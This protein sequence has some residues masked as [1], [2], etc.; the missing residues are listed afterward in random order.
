MNTQLKKVLLSVWPWTRTRMKAAPMLVMV[1]AL[2][3]PLAACSAQLTRTSGKSTSSASTSALAT[4]AAN[5][6]KTTTPTANASTSSTPVANSSAATSPTSPISPTSTITP[7]PTPSTATSSGSGASATPA[8]TP[9]ST[10]TKGTKPSAAQVAAI[11][12]VIQHANQEQIQAL[13]AGNPASMQDTSTSSYYTELVQTQNTMENSGVASIQLVKLTWGPITLTNATTAR[14]TDVETWN[15]TFSGQAG[16][17]QQSNT[18][19]YVLVL[20]NG[21]WK[22]QSDQQPTT[23]QSPSGNSNPSGNPSPVAPTIP[24]PSAPTSPNALSQS[25]NWAGYAASG[26]DFTSVSGSWGVPKVT[27]AAATSA[28]ATWVGIGGVNSQD[29]IQ[30]GTEADVQ[31]GQVTYVAWYELLPQSQQI[32]PLTVNAGDHLDVTINEQASGKWHIVIKDTTSDQTYQTTVNYSSSKSSAEWIEEAPAIGQ[33]ALVP[34]DNFG[35]VTFTGASAVEGGK[36]ETIAQA[37]G[38]AIT[39]ENQTGQALAQTS[40][41]SSDGSSFTVTRTTASATPTSPYGHRYHRFPDG[42][43][44]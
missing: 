17:L 3:I 9:T 24:N 13:A 28:S 39:M 1:L 41:L 4:S 18:N 22:I 26:K 25:A 12:Q 37:S 35:S 31:N 42:F 20:Q 27:P 5:G 2:A 32:I 43:S 33:N 16:T 14:A 23:S 40:G 10:T 29:L 34:L 8:S 38:Q 44:G 21:A 30:A 19:I 11:K 7:T 36:T 15:T 6:G